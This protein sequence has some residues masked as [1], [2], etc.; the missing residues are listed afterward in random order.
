M[1]DGNRDWRS[2]PCRK[3]GQAKRPQPQ[4]AKGAKDATSL[5]LY[6]CSRSGCPVGLGVQAQPLGVRLLAV[7]KIKA[8]NELIA[9]ISIRGFVQE[10][11]HAV[12]SLSR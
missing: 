11:V 5:H 2:D 6:N 12:R 8:A 1:P 4:E 3:K 9:G 7:H 10:D